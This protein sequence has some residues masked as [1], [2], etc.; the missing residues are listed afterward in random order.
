MRGETVEEILDYAR[1][2]VAVEDPTDITIGEALC[3]LEKL[4][5][6]YERAYRVAEAALALY[7]ADK[8]VIKARDIHMAL[9][10]QRVMLSGEREAYGK[11][12]LNARDKLSQALQAQGSAHSLLGRAIEEELTGGR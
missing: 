12:V 4:I 2:I 9:L 3:L 7:Q 10:S 8:C 5:E 1:E 6:G 11:Q